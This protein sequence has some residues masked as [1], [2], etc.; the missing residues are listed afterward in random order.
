MTYQKALRQPE[1]AYCIKIKGL[2]HR[3][4]SQGTGVGVQPPWSLGE[5]RILGRLSEEYGNYLGQNRS[6]SD[7]TG[8][9]S[10]PHPTPPHEKQPMPL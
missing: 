9:G 10:L 7:K 8:S 2:N 6:F 1:L 4:M 5:T 3:G